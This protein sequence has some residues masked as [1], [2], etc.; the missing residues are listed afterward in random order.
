MVATR[1]GMLA[2]SASMSVHVNDGTSLLAGAD[3]LPLLAP[4]CD[5]S[6][7][8]VA[9]DA[10]PASS[11]TEYR[12]YPVPEHHSGLPYLADV[13]ATRDRE[14]LFFIGLNRGVC[15]EEFKE[16]DAWMEGENRFMCMFPDKTAVIS[17]FVAP[18]GGIYKNNFMFR[19]KIPEEF[20]HLIV[21]GAESTNLHVDLHALHEPEAPKKGM[22]KVR[23]FPSQK[24]TDTPKI[25]QIPVCHAGYADVE[26]KYE[27]AAYTRVQSTYKTQLD[28][29]GR[30]FERSTIHRIE[31]WL[32][33]HVDQ[34]FDH[35]II[36]DNDPKPHGPIEGLTRPYVESG[37]VT[38]R[39]FPLKDCKTLKGK[40]E[41]WIR[42]FGQAAGGLAA[43]HRLG[44]DGATYFAHM[45]VDEF[46]VVY[47][48]DTTVLELTKQL[49]TPENKTDV[50]YFMSIVMDHCDGVT[51]QSEEDSNLETKQCFTSSHASGNKLIMKQDTMIHFQ[52][53]FPL[54][55]RKWRKPKAFEVHRRHGAGYLAHYRGEMWPGKKKT[56]WNERATYFDKYLAA[57][58]K[59]GGMLHLQTQ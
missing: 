44:Q 39:W 40:H 51:V 21:P 28:K 2:F 12:S 6:S 3:G 33:Y 42:R 58:K 24:I 18:T 14:Y 35:F 4:A 9:A 26:K 55:T 20:K 47:D 11:C 1:Q 53:H 29:N 34:G 38:Y 52:V 5:K 49:L 31:E 50:L 45:D 48:E 43:M 41:G 59:N 8:Q 13:F 19:C 54:M 23:W 10:A 22:N 32:D 27:L 15:S 36:Y 25:A 7:D 37:L 57:R 16:Q 56:N 46:F 17:E 30:S